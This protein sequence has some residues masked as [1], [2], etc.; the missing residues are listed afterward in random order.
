MKFIIELSVVVVVVVVFFDEFFL[1][2]GINCVGIIF[3][4]GNVD[5]VCL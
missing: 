5:F 4:G 3:S 1:I 2:F